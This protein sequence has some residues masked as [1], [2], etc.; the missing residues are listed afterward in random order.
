MPA[1]TLDLCDQEQSV[2]LSYL[3][4]DVLKCGLDKWTWRVKITPSQEQLRALVAVFIMEITVWI[5]ENHTYMVGDQIYKQDDGA[6]IGLELAQVIGM[7]LMVDYDREL[8][9]TIQNPMY[10]LNLVDHSQYEDDNT[11]VTDTPTREMDQVSL[12]RTST[13]ILKIIADNIH[14]GIQVETDHQFNNPH[15]YVCYIRHVG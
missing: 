7:V 11:I 8:R 5:M 9:D 15:N 1:R 12:T 3:D 4:S 2:T 10:N 6:P 13:D 14:A